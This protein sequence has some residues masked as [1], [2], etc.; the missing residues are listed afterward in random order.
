MAY[1]R[2][3]EQQVPAAA[4]AGIHQLRFVRRGTGQRNL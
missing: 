3:Q 1:Q 4:A 2:Q